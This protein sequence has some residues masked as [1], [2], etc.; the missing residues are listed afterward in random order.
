[1]NVASTPMVVLTRVPT[2]LGPIHA[3]VGWDTDLPPMDAPVKVLLLL[4]IVH[5]RDNDSVDF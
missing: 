3:V 2:P 5:Y 4:F 1:M